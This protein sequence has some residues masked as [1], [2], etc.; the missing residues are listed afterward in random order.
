MA[1]GNL[2]ALSGHSN[3]KIDGYGGDFGSFMMYNIT[4]YPYNMTQFRQ[5]LAYSINTSEIVQQSIFGYGVAANNAQGGMPD[6]YGSYNPSQMQ[7]P[8]NV[9][10]AINLL[11]F[12]RIHGRWRSR[13]SSAPSKRYKVLCDTLH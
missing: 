6:T 13:S 8:Y 4:Q 7:Y 12:D 11:A 5:A 1:F 10:T 2:A 9:T 3:I